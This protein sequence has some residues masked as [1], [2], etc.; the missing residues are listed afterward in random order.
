[1]T[2]YSTDLI[3]LIPSLRISGGVQEALLL[4]DR[5]R[6]RGVRVRIVTLWGTLKEFSHDGL[7]VDRLSNFMA[8][9]ATAA[10]QFPL[11]LKRFAAYLRQPDLAGAAVMLTH[12]ST[13]PFAWLAYSRRWYCFNQDIEWMFVP[14]GIPRALLRR[15][16][17]ATSRRACVI[18]TNSFIESKFADHG[19]ASIAQVSIWADPFWLATDT[20]TPRR[21][22]DVVM[23]LRKGRMK[24]LDLYLELLSRL[25]SRP[26]IISVVVTPDAEI[27]AKVLGMAARVLLHPSNSELR[28]LYADSRLF[29]SLSDT[30]GFGLTP[31]EAMGQ[32]C[33]P[34][35]RDS[36]GVRCY[37]TG[38]LEKNL[39]PLAE[40]INEI[41][42][43]IE[44]LL[45]D[46]ERLDCDS[47]SAI[48]IFRR[49]VDQ[50]DAHRRAAI[51][52]IVDSLSTN[53]G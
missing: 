40:P 25:R 2:S 10:L 28:S 52:S 16:I 49:G 29:V 45:S 6:Q 23:L 47:A 48:A 42:I 3:V 30:E 27:H 13:F 15:F 8:K 1:M 7:P 34:L 14:R 44:Q 32:G 31:L 17:L 11:L 24:R 43:R 51:R 5:L 37:M 46:L 50:T 41:C 39:V 19:V 18:T 36:G 9:R 38:P 53:E 33:I 22:V 12:F 4:A 21:S 26:E 35:C 20:T